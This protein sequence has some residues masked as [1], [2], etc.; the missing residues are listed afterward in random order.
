VHRRSR[1]IETDEP[2]GGAA[3]PLVHLEGASELVLGAPSGTKL[4]ALALQDEA[5][6]V[7]ESAVV[8]FAGDLTIESAKMPGG[9]GDGVPIVQL[10]GNG[11]VVLAL[12][13]SHAAL[14]LA[15]G[16]DLV[17]RAHGILGWVGRVTPRA[18][19]QSDAPARVRGL[20]SLRGEGLVLV[21]A[22]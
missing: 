17:L 6:T 8:A 10:R 9:E 12:P 15:E 5:I 4:V 2:L 14:E 7:R 22:R 11:P 16:R 20:V 3:A 13:P 1:G 19:P 21:D 18:V